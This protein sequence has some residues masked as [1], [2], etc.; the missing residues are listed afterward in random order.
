M[1]S[2]GAGS[3]RTELSAPA[4]PNPDGHTNGAYAFG[5]ETNTSAYME[6]VAPVLKNLEIDGAVRFDHYSLAGNATTPKLAFK[7][8]PRCRTSPRCGR[9]RP[10]RRRCSCR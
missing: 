1:V 2:V 6:F 3:F 8:T 5:S 7:Y 9:W 10:C 4:M